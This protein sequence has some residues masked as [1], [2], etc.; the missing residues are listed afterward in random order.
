MARTKKAAGPQARRPDGTTS[1]PEPGGAPPIVVGIGASAGGLES[2]QQLLAA[3]PTETGMAFVHIQH[4]DPNH[5]SVMAELVRSAT[6]LDVREAEDDQA[7][8]ADCVYIGPP[9]RDV[10]IAGHRL[11][12]VAPAEPQ[13]ARL[14]IDFFFRSLAREHGHRSIGVVLSGTGSDGALGIR[15]IKGAGGMTIAQDPRTAKY[16]G[17]PRSAIGTQLVDFVVA[18]RDVPRV[19]VEYS[20]HPYV[21]ATDL[22]APTATGQLEQ[23]FHLLR[24]HTGHDFAHYKQ[25]TIRRRI[26]RRMAVHRLK[27]LEDYLRHLQRFPSEV[28]ALFKDLLIGVTN[29]F[30]DPEAFRAL[31]EKVVPR[32]F[33]AGG[34]SSQLRV[35]LP[36]CSTGEEAYSIAML[37][38]EHAD[39]QRQPRKACIFA[40]DIDPSAIDV[41]RT[42]VY[43]ESIAADV[44]PE[45]LDKFFTKENGAYRIA[46]RIREMVIFAVQDVLKDP[47][48]SRIDLISCRNLLIYLEPELQK[49]LMQLFHAVL[50][51]GGCLF[52]GASETV[53]EAAELFGHIDKKWKLYEKK[54][55]PTHPL[56]GVTTLHQLNEGT[57]LPARP[58]EHALESV[59]PPGI[60]ELTARLLLESYAPACVVV[61]EQYD[62][63]YFQGRTSRYLEMPA[64]EPHL[65]VLKMARDEVAR[66][67]RTALHRAHKEAGEVVRDRVTVTD[68]G[69]VRFL[70][71]RVKPFRGPRPSPH[72]FLVAF[73][74]L[75][76]AP[77]ASAAPG[78]DSNPA[79]PRV[80]ELERKLAS[81]KESLQST[82]EEVETS[83]EE[84][85][86]TNEE[87]QSANEELQSTNEE[88]ETSKEELQSVNEELMTVNTELQKKL[89]ELSQAN[90]DLTNLLNSTEIGTIFLDND[91]RIKRFTPAVGRLVNL[92][93]SDVGRPI[94][95]IVTQILDDDLAE[96]ARDV[97]RSLAFQETEVRTRDGRTYLRRILPYRTVDNVIDGVV[98]TFVNITEVRE[99]QRMVEATLVYASSIVDA[100]RQPVVLLNKEGRV[101]QVNQTFYNFFQVRREETLGARLQDLDGA[102]WATPAVRAVLEG[103][104]GGG[105][106]LEGY[107]VVQDLPGLGRRTLRL[108]ARRTEFGTKAVAGEQELT[109]LTIEDVTGLKS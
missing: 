75:G 109:V 18:P 50:N 97:L 38:A 86:S 35:W 7:I 79:D 106:P 61:D 15:A 83:N 44:S 49:R 30:R 103:V 14:P 77:E 26:E 57:A 28:D 52:L 59:P 96:H 85:R 37:L 24:E 108:Y 39:R 22:F 46:K 36:A 62:I 42:A 100:V 101:V 19:L 84:L 95:D 11:R 5:K 10:A 27:Q 8:E 51:P 72:L 76:A 47:P 68:D 41:A 73:E 2:L 89:E 32:L 48:F 78:H 94:M 67:L 54:A 9:N 98:V 66:E 105:P 71:L 29:F 69:A 63:L 93:P 107:E 20:R 6:H 23:I 82:V 45:R 21:A 90:N 80:A 64:G 16:D 53:G 12:L 58:V 65:N 40:T 104:L 33:E 25:N 81:M 4:L 43:H 102:R 34:S 99:A 3:M 92:I 91:L 70:R 13:R 87:L 60:G 1:K 88:L 31:E 56:I 17:M 74:D 55:V